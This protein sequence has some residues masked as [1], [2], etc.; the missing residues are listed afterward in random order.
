VEPNEAV[1]EPRVELLGPEVEPL[2]EPNVEPSVVPRLDPTLDPRVESSVD[3]RVD[4]SVDP[5][6]DP[7]VDPRVDPNVDPRVEPSVDPSVDPRV[8]VRSVVGVLRKPS[9]E[10]KLGLIFR[11]GLTVAVVVVVG[12][13]REAFTRRRTVGLVLRL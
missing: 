1:V 7:S 6:V 2:V 8:D 12:G 3:P 9:V 11:N 10:L 4:P 5:R 13:F